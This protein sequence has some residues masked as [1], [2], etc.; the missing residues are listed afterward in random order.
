MPP[1][2]SFNRR[3]LSLRSGSVSAASES[4]RM[5]A[6]EQALVMRHENRRLKKAKTGAIRVNR[7]TRTKNR[8]KCTL[9]EN[10][11]YL[12]RFVL[13]KSPSSSSVPIAPSDALAFLLMK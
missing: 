2:V 4:A 6:C 1:I 5:R 13:M 12:A 10:F 3:K 11:L 8:N 9:E 7:K